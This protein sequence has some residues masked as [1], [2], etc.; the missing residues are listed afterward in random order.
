[1]CGGDVR[2]FFDRF[3]AIDFSILYPGAKTFLSQPVSALTD[4][5]ATEHVSGIQTSRQGLLAGDE[6]RQC[7]NAC[8]KSRE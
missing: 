3:P 7:D 6:A 1:M 8:M 5:V 2:F 4:D